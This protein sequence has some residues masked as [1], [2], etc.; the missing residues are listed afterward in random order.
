MTLSVRSRVCKSLL[1]GT[2]SV[3]LMAWGS[4]NASASSL[5]ID[6]FYPT[7]AF[8]LL[9]NTYG[10]AAGQ[11]G[12]WNSPLIPG[13]IGP[14]PLFDLTGGP[15]IATMSVSAFNSNFQNP[16]SVPGDDANLLSDYFYTSGGGAYSVSFAGLQNGTYTVFL[17]APNATNVAIGGGNI[18]GVN[19]PYTPALLTPIQVPGLFPGQNFIVVNGVVVSNGTMLIQNNGGVLFDYGL[20]GL[21][22]R[23]TP[24]DTPV[25]EPA[26]MLL[27]GTGLA[28]VIRRR[29]QR[30]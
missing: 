9:P 2:L 25:P 23:L 17:Y 8:S 20:S 30:R 4:V 11:P 18:N 7:T 15:T 3:F 29:M 6:F 24:T 13:P 26:T 19:Y 28:F 14:L 21:Q 1:V 22:L 16:F 12:F 27:V 10:A 5:N